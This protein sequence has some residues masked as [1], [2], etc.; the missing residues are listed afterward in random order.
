MDL[1]NRKNYIKRYLG[2][3]L[4][5][6]DRLRFEE[7]LG[8]DSELK[9]LYRLESIAQDIVITNYALDFKKEIAKEFEKTASKKK[10]NKKIF[11]VGGVVSVVLLA[12]VIHYFNDYPKT[13][14]EAVIEENEGEPMNDNLE[15]E[16]VSHEKGENDKVLAEELKNKNKRSGSEYLLVEEGRHVLSLDTTITETSEVIEAAIFVFD[17]LI[18]DELDIEAPNVKTE[19]EQVVVASAEPC[20]NFKSPIPVDITA[21]VYGQE[22]GVI[23]VLT[24]QITIGEL[25]SEFSISKDGFSSQVMYEYL[26][27]GSYTLLS[28]DNTGCIV[29]QTVVIPD[30]YC[31]DDYNHTFT[32]RS[33]GDWLF[34]ISEIE[35]TKEVIIRDASGNSRTFNLGASETELSWN[36]NWMNGSSAD[37]GL[38]IFYISYGDT[39]TCKKELTIFD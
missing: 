25:P 31:S 14:N 4:S 26:G 32:P 38:V 34:P 16:S 22:T 37:I 7:A 17:S 39:E 9:E 15:S 24:D 10:R 23:S 29:K 12:F 27:S 5:N 3:D 20:S 28:R 19:K 36:G 33:E 18:N 21:S 8:Q 6:E 13:N 35:L 1:T 11:I 30:T 2:G